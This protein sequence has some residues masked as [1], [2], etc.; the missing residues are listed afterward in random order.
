VPLDE[1]RACHPRR[2]NITLHASGVPHADSAGIHPRCAHLAVIGSNVFMTIAWYWHLRYK[3]TPLFA[4]ILISWALAFV[5][6]C[7]DQPTASVAQSIRPR[8]SRPFRK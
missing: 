8:N 1:P 2:P 4:V 6:Y 7:L 5:E 3:E